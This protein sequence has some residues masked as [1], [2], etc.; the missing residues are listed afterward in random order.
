[1]PERDLRVSVLLPAYNAEATLRSCLAS[2]GRQTESRW[3]CVVVDDGSTDGTAAI[4]LDAARADV[5]FRVIHAPHQGIVE[6]LNEGLAH[7]RAP[8][9]ARM[10]ADDVMRR[11]RLARQADTL[12]GDSSLSAVGSHVRIFP[13]SGMAPRLREYEHWLNGL[14]S[15]DDIA[16]DAFVECPVAHPTL[17]MRRRMADLRYADTGW[18]E[19]YDL[20]LRALGVGLRIGIV[21]K[22]LVAWRDRSDSLSRTHGRYTLSQFT[23]CK[24]HHLAAG[25]LSHSDA[26]VLCGYG[27]TGKSLRRV[28]AALGKHPSHVVEVK[29]SR[30]GKRIH[31]APVIPHGGLR[32]VAGRPIVVSVARAGPRA[33][34][35]ASLTAMGFVEGRDFVC[36]A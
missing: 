5:R 22:R 21:T 10:D 25:F 32:G 16:R 29:P 3:E 8:L 34:A 17:M 24:A 9:I 19:D 7:C 35:R 11:D 2:I 13:R 18:P 14:R 33:E 30:L 4:A 27:A 28:L 12:A 1:M 6:A 15:A 20:I 23:A 26:Y 36:A 31:G